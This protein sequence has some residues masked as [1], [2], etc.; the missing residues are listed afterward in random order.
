MTTTAPTSGLLLVHPLW[1]VR[2]VAVC[3]CSVSRVPRWSFHSQKWSCLP[4]NDPL[5]T[6]TPLPTIRGLTAGV[7]ELAD[8]RDSKSRP[9]NR[10]R[11]RFPPPASLISCVWS[12]WSENGSPRLK[13]LVPLNTANQPSLPPRKLPLD[14]TLAFGILV[15]SGTSSHGVLPDHDP[16][17]PC[18]YGTPLGS[19]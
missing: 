11:V 1:T 7:A 15:P 9:G 3:H 13:P 14:P 2:R 5:T 12:C 18:R 16:V 8:A 6:S 17:V 4:A 19:A 10:V